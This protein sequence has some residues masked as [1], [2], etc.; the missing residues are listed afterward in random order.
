[1][2]AQS[3]SASDQEP[4]MPF[5]ITANRLDTGLAVYRDAVG[6]WSVHLDA[7]ALLTE[8][9]AQ[10]GLQAAGHDN[11]VVDL[12]IIDVSLDSGRPVPSRLRE[13]IRAFGPTVKSD[14]RPGAV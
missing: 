11:A 5:V 7:A 2:G 6:A 14:H 12:N 8:T 3:A 9:E 1:M 4:P 13:R 10:M